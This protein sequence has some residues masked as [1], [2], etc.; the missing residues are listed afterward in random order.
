MTPAATDRGVHI[1]VV[2]EFFPQLP[3]GGA[4][5]GFPVE[6]G[7]LIQRA[8]VILR[9]AMALETPAHAVGFGMVDDFHVIHLSVTGHAT[10]APVHVNRMVEVDVIRRLV[11]PYPG[12]RVAGFPG[13]ADGSQFRAQRLDLGVAVHA[14]L[15]SGNVGVRGFLHPGVAVAA[16]HSQLVDVQRVIEGHGLGWLIANPGIFGR[17]VIGHAGDHAGRY[18]RN[19]D[20]DFDWKPVGP[21]WE[22]VGHEGWGVGKSV[23]IRGLG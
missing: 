6:V 8:K 23:E 9:S 20:Q 11:N 21:S 14:G 18:H 7:D 22:N 17:K 3:L 15:R 10:D 19:A 4:G 1:P 5:R 12:N 2:D 16:I 13:F